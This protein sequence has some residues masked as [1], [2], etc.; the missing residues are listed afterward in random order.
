MFT[1]EEVIKAARKEYGSPVCIDMIDEAMKAKTLEEAVEII[2]CDS[3]YWDNA[4][5]EF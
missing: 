3:Y 2:V 1:K 5:P 4:G